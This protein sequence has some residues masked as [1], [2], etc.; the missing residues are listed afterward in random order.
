M[1]YK[2]YLEFTHDQDYIDLYKYYSTETFFDIVG[3]ARQENPHSSFWRWLLDKNSAH[4]LHE[5]PFR[6]FLET[7]AWM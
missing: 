2:Q 1:D 3:V 4:G 7:V 6:K 5:M